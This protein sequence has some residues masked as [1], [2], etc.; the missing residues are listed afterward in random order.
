MTGR[1]QK[2]WADFGGLK[3]VA[4]LDFE[5]A[6][7]LANNSGCSI[8]DQ[9]HPRGKLDAA[10]YRVIGDAY[11]KVEAAELW[12][13]GAQPVAQ[14]ALLLAGEHNAAQDGAAKM[15]LEL[16]HQFDV[17]NEEQEFTPYDVLVIPDAARPS[18]DLVE[19]LNAYLDGGG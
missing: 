5:C 12:C 13:R 10:V 18:P 15:L 4:Q 6:S 17:I 1:F 9:L 2:M 7:M 8:G 3:T 14:V 16:H 11:A 19:K